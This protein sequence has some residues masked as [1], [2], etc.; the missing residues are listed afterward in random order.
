MYRPWFN[1]GVTIETKGI[2]AD[3]RLHRRL[4][5]PKLPDQSHVRGG[6][7]ERVEH[8]QR[9]AVEPVA[10]AL[11]RHEALPEAPIRC[12]HERLE[13]GDLASER[14]GWTLDAD[15]A[16]VLLEELPVAAHPVVTNC[17]LA[18]PLDQDPSKAGTRLHAAV[19]GGDELRSAAPGNEP[20]A[21]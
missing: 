19:D 14:P 3:I 12:P 1:D 6:L 21:A 2:S 7:V 18:V 9:Q 20:L 16:Y 8:A 4:R 17:V 13:A 15:V 5:A 11:A 10:V